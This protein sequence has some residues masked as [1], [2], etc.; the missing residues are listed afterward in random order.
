MER[1][2]D[3]GIELGKRDLILPTAVKRSDGS[4]GANWKV[5]CYRSRFLIVCSGI[6]VVGV[7]S[8]VIYYQVDSNSYGGTICQRVDGENVT[9][10]L[11]VMVNG[12]FEIL[13]RSRV[14]QMLG[15]SFPLVGN[16]SCYTNG[17]DVK[18]Q[19]PEDVMQI[20]WSIISPMMGLFILCVGIGIKNRRIG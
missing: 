11:R 3:S 1:G 13:P 15:D 5:R 8:A 20:L 2:S 9:D 17:I 14:G 19:D 4:A 12:K 18:T 16:F 7:L 6:I 10:C